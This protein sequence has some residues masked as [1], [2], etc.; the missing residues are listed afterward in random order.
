MA[1]KAARR[2]AAATNQQNVVIIFILLFSTILLPNL[3]HCPRVFQAQ[4]RQSIIQKL[5]SKIENQRVARE[6][7]NIWSGKLA[8]IEALEPAPPVLQ[9]AQHPSSGSNTSR[10]AAAAG[11]PA[12]R[13]TPA[14]EMVEVYVIVRAGRP[15][16]ILNPEPSSAG[17]FIVP[18]ESW[19]INLEQ[20]ER[21]I[22]V[23]IPRVCLQGITTN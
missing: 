8:A 20:G 1:P 10:A 17:T 21:R 23:R 5:V 11:G 14:V 9:P 3:M 16:V 22:P 19:P 6:L 7:K 18:S 12:H 15:L 4:L 13:A 2:A